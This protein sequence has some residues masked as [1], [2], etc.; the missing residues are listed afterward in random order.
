MKFNESGERPLNSEEK[1]VLNDAELIKGGA[2]I[3]NGSLTIT[4]DQHEVALREMFR[5]NVELAQEQVRSNQEFEQNLTREAH[6]ERFFRD[7]QDLIYLLYDS[8]YPQKTNTDPDKSYQTCV[9]KVFNFVENPDYKKFLGAEA[10][11]FAIAL[12][13]IKR[14]QTVAGYDLFW[15]ASEEWRIVDETLKQLFNKYDKQPR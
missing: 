2:R 6:F 12:K 3:E 5:S 7:L 9:K 4:E 8:R 15:K 11:V 10:G 13:E 14:K 1:R